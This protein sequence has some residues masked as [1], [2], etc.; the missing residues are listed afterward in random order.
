MRRVVGAV[1]KRYPAAITPDM[2]AA[3]GMDCTLCIGYLRER[4]PC[5]GCRGDD[6]N[7]PSHC[8][9]CVIKN[10]DQIAAGESGFC[11]ECAKFPCSRLRQLDKRYR[12]KYGMSMIENLE[13]IREGGLDAFVAFEQER[14][15][16]SE[17]GG[18][19]SVHRDACIYCGATKG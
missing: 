18:V 4:K 16:C 13:R 17:C 5:A 8:A 9:V 3:C 2:I 19:I 12:T 14:W 10:C 11:Y 1:E 7:K 6:A 15:E